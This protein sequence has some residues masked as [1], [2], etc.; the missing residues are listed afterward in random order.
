[1]LKITYLFLFLFS[2]DCCASSIN[3]IICPK[4]KVK[5]GDTY[6]K[7][8]DYCGKEGNFSAGMRH[9]G[10]NNIPMRFKTFTKKYPDGSKIRV[11]FLDGKVG[12]L[13]DL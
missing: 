8:I 1:M 13:F 10:K 7:F 9:L 12:F 3:F 4:G 11:L 2:F 6:E 5:H